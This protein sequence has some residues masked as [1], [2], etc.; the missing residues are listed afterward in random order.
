[1]CRSVV[2]VVTL[3][4]EWRTTPF[5][6]VVLQSL[7]EAAAMDPV[8]ATKESDAAAC[9]AALEVEEMCTDPT[10]SIRANSPIAATPT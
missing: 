9:R 4:T 3:P 5:N 10:A 6:P 7:E 8:P 2:S 1:M